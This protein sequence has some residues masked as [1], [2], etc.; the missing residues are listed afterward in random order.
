MNKWLGAVFAWVFPVMLTM[1]AG[2]DGAPVRPQSFPKVALLPGS[3]PYY[4]SVM[5]DVQTNQI[6]YILFDGNVANGYERL[7]FWVPDDMNF[8]TP[9]IYK[10]NEETKRFGPI[11][12]RPRHDQDDID[13]VW[14]FGWSRAGGAYEHFDYQTGQ[15]RKGTTTVYPQFWFYCDYACK[16]RSAGARNDAQVDLTIPGPIG[17]HVWTNMPAALQPWHTLNYYMT[18]KLVREK[19]ATQ[20]RFAG[21]LYYGS[22]HRCVVRTMP[23]ETVC[24]L[25]VAPYLGQMSYSN[26][27]TWTQAL[28]EGVN[29]KLDYGWYDMNWNI[30]C[31]GLRVYPR[32]DAA[33][34]ANPFPV[35]RFDD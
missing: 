18:V 4:A 12:F 10:L 9:K 35:S 6:G 24:T 19:D 25:T 17:A 16:P 2:L 5:L 3:I 21:Q 15:T 11:K 20:A 1:A 13:I 28:I 27:L 30:V 26:D 7:Y 14:S 23:R 33:V 8:R 34:R 29:L 31:H 22:G 32:L